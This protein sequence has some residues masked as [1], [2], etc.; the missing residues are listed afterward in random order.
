M[1][2]TELELTAINL[3]AWVEHRLADTATLLSIPNVIGLKKNNCQFK[4]FEEFVKFT[5]KR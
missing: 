4:T 2:N 1:I 5:L 3:K